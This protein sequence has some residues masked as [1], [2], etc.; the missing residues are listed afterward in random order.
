MAARMTLLPD[1]RLTALR[2]ALLA[3]LNDAAV[4]VSGPAFGSFLDE[5]M[6]SL[7]IE[8]FHRLGADEGTV[9]LLDE[10]KSALVP[11]FNSGPHAERIVGRFRQDLGAGMISMVAVTE[12]PICENEVCRNERQ[13][14]RLD[15]EL[16]LKTWAMLAVPFS[17]FSELRG[18]VSCVQFLPAGEAMPAPAGFSAEHLGHLQH[19]AGLLSRLIEYRI[20]AQCLGLDSL[21]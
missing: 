20:L 1:G 13:D 21:G 5:S 17:Y 15:H 9:W 11:Q 4:E 3:A 12:Q 6:R 2:P 7:L 8:G 10:S 19:V 18:V 16:G 14:R